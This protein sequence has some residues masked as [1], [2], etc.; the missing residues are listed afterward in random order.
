MLCRRLASTSAWALPPTIRQLLSSERHT[1]S[2]VQVQGWIKSL[3]RQ[4]NVTFA[5]I[6]DGSCA[7][8]VQAVLS[9]NVSSGLKGYIQSLLQYCRGHS[10]PFSQLV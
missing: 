6:N 10:S 4:K 2:K 9:N 8:G 7:A 1:Q 3:R 5:V